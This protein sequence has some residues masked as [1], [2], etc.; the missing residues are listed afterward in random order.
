LTTFQQE[1]P[2]KCLSQKKVDSIFF[3][4]SFF[5]SDLFS[6]EDFCHKPISGISGFALSRDRLAGTVG[7]V[8]D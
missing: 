4:L 3:F 1:V 6:I 2:K 8:A 7:K 5:K